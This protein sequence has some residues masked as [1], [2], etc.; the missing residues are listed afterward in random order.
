M[1]IFY[2]QRF[3]AASLLREGYRVKQPIYSNKIIFRL[4]NQAEQPTR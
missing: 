3:L 2:L 4:V 1:I